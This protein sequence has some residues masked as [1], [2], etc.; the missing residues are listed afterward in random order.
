MNQK[1]PAGVFIDNYKEHESNNSRC[2]N[3]SLA[4]FLNEIFPYL[5]DLINSFEKS[6]NT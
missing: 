3:L 4:N 6:D 5:K 1:N 2:K